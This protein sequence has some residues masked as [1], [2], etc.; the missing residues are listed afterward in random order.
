MEMND[1]MEVQQSLCGETV[2]P[3]SQNFGFSICYFVAEEYIQ[4]L[5]TTVQSMDVE[6]D[7]LL[8]KAQSA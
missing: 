7:C 5:L 2:L 6:V 1:E 4:S 3:A 8:L